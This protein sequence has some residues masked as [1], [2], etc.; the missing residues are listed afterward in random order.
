MKHDR[1]T[2]YEREMKPNGI[3]AKHTNL[4]DKVIFVANPYLLFFESQRTLHTLPSPTSQRSNQRLPK[5]AIY[6]TPTIQNL[7]YYGRRM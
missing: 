3:T 1:I 2:Y 7:E 6:P 4:S 5:S